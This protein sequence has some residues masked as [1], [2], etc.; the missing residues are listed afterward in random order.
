MVEGDDSRPSEQLPPINFVLRELA[1]NES[2]VTFIYSALR[3]LAERYGLD[4]V[5]IVLVSTSFSTQVFRLDGREIDTNAVAAPG[6]SP[7]VYCL[8]DIVPVGELETIYAACQEAYSY[9]FVRNIPPVVAPPSRNVRRIGTD[10]APPIAPSPVVA[11]AS[12]AA[13]VTTTAKRVR[14]A[15][16]EPSVTAQSAR[17][18]LSRL[19]LLIDVTVLIMTAAGIHGPLRLLLGLVL[20]I[21]IPGWCIVAPLKLDNTPLELG[22]ILT[23]SLS[24]LM[25]VAQILMTLGLWHLVALE[26][27]TCA[28]CLPFLLNQAKMVTLWS[29]NRPTK[30]AP[31]HTKVPSSS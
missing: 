20:G 8:P 10:P 17:V 4:D 5:A 30:S 2:G 24:L 1:L 29:Q 15:R 13:T 12:P 27:I 22:L 11:P 16:R 9:R 6:T 3:A 7:G 26:E 19:L 25:M 21:V 23:V 28:V 31:R 18:A 14:L